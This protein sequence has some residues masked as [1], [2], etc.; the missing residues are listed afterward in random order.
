LKLKEFYLKVFK[1]KVMKLLNWQKLKQQTKIVADKFEKYHKEQTKLYTCGKFITTNVFQNVITNEYKSEQTNDNFC[2]S[3]FCY[4]CEK[5]KSSKYQT[6]LQEK[7][8]LAAQKNQYVDFLTLT[9]PNCNLDELD[10]TLKKFSSDFKK[11]R[12]NLKKNYG[13]IGF[14]KSVEITYT[15]KKYLDTLTD[16]EKNVYTDYE[17]KFDF[18]SK[19]E[20]IEIPKMKNGKKQAHPHYHLLIVYEKFDMDKN[21]D[22]LTYKTLWKRLSNGSVFVKKFN[23]K[24]IEKSVKEITKYM[25]KET[26][27]NHFENEDMDIVYKQ[28]KRKQFYSK[29]GVLDFKLEDIKKSMNKEAKKEKYELYDKSKNELVVSIKYRFVNN[30]YLKFNEIWKKQLTKEQQLILKSFLV[31]ERNYQKGLFEKEMQELYDSLIA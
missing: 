23:T 4:V 8:E 14:F 9:I 10:K 20:Y 7:L 11:L 21:P 1:K 3:K 16:E 5:I 15:D 22:F 2:K 12:D 27:Y 31:E 28:L 30:S 18:K 29:G 26:D 6:G 19:R 24:N 17:I 13:M 25:T